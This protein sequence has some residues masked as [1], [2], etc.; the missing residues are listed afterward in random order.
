LQVKLSRPRRIGGRKDKQI[1]H[2]TVFDMDGGIVTVG[3]PMV[4]MRD[5]IGII[6][7]ATHRIRR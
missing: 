4:T 5:I 6:I 7:K 1:G 2:G 3:A